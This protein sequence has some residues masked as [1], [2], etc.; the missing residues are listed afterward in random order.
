V[1]NG[2]TAAAAN[3]DHLDHGV[4]WYVIDY[5]ENAHY[6]APAWL[7]KKHYSRCTALLRRAPCL[8]ILPFH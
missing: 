4:L 5:I 6:F 7:K 2:I 3:A 1:F 8:H